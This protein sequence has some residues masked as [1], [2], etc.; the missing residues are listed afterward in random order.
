[1]K[2]D[3]EPE[4]APYRPALTDYLCFHVVHMCLLGRNELVTSDLGDG[5][6][7]L[8][9]TLI[10]RRPV[11][12]Y[13]P[14]GRGLLLIPQSSVRGCQGGAME[15]NDFSG[16]LNIAAFPARITVRDI[17]FTSHSQGKRSGEHKNRNLS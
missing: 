3:N 8:A 5:D 15:P 4:D 12:M 2:S 14:S 13:D 9:M 7:D 17:F 16:E 10:K 1:M 6:L 11:L